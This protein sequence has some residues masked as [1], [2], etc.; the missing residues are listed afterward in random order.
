MTQE[1]IGRDL[2]NVLRLM[3]SIVAMNLFDVL[4]VNFES[5]AIFKILSDAERSYQED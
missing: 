3:L 5:I 4:A 1:I 2:P